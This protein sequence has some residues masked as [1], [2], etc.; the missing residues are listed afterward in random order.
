MWKK[1]TSWAGPSHVSP[2]F[3]VVFNDEFYTV[4]FMREVTIPPNW[5][6]LVHLI[7]QSD[8]PDNIDFK[9]TWFIPDIE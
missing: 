8:A 9:D 6:D 7:S 1:W 5:T 2:Q 4:P 3:N